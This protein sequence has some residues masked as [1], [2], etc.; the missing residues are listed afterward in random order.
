M[1]AELPETEDITLAGLGFEPMGADVV[2]G[3]SGMEMRKLLSVLALLSL[4]G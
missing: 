4:N 1:P 2:T 3:P